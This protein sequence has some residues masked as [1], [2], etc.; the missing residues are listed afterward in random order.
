MAYTTLS[1]ILGQIPNSDVIACTDDDNI[2]NINQTIL[3][4]VISNASG[5]IDRWVCNIYTT[6]FTGTLPSS[7]SSFAL[8]IACYMLYRRRLVPD[9]KNKFFP[10]Y[11]DV[12]SFLKKVNQ[13]E[14]MLET[15]EE[16][17]YSQVATTGRQSIYG[18]GNVLSNSM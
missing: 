13:G 5:Y 2:G 4:T 12:V 8:T 14:M 15:G 10:D 11:K 7:V 9:E 17:I 18:G 3:D 16:R 6:P 1:A